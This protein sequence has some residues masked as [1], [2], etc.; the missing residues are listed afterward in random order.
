MLLVYVTFIVDIY[1]YVV[2]CTI[3][4]IILYIYFLLRRVMLWYHSLLPLHFIFLIYYHVMSLK[5][6]KVCDVI[7]YVISS[8]SRV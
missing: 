5:Y 3:L 7:T 6:I 1:L 2:S 4:F 8:R